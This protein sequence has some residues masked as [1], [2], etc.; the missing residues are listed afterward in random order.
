YGNATAAT[1]WI[2]RLATGG[3]RFADAHAQNVTT[4]PSHANIFSGKY[5][6]D[7]GVRDNLGFR[8]PATIET[9]ATLLKARGYRTGAFV[10]AFPLASRFG[11]GRGFD[12]YDD[13]FV[14][15]QARPAF[16]EQERRGAETVAL[17]RRWI[18]RGS[19]YFCW[20]HLYEPHF[21]YAPPEPFASRFRDNPYL[22][23]VA[24]V[25]AAL[26]PLLDPIV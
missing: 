25:D 11:L 16:V 21:P 10:S 24:A 14:D 8:F 22:G 13:S 26:A 19:P 6:T 18:D 23:E 4:L 15:A 3:V 1:P 20:V 12:V 9:L 17:A 5:P 7:H 2:D